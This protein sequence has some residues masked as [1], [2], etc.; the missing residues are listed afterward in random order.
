MSD[1]SPSI[2]GP[3]L[4]N[5]HPP[6]RWRLFDAHNHLHDERFGGCQE[7][8]VRSCRASGIRRMIVN[9]S[10]EADWRQVAE[11]ARRFP[12]LVQPAFGLHPWYVHERS[13]RWESTLGQLLDEHPGASLGEIGLDRWILDCPPAA[14]AAIDPALAELQAAPLSEQLEVFRR[15]LEI[16]NRHDRPASVHCLQAWGPL[17]ECLRA[18][19]RPVVGFLLHS[20]GGPAELVLP[21]AR[22][23]AY[24][25]FPGY[26]L[27]ARKARQ[28]EAFRQVPADRLLAETD[29]PDQ[30]LP[31]PGQIRGN[32]SP[33]PVPEVHQLL[34]PDGRPLNH[35]ANLVAVYHGLAALRQW[36]LA[37]LTPQLE[38]NFHSLFG[39]D[40]SAFPGPDA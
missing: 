16:A 13:P 10:S 34:S 6:P 40:P 11:L 17:H 23:G 15:Q 27:H 25:G 24:F 8:L 37:T 19:P 1:P 38:A 33:T 32:G 30:R 5:Q 2:E 29:A 31:A 26:Y 22:L 14:R 28:R 36:D 39:P 20:Y 7:D 18:G 35:P 21:L 3:L 4:R 12:D 9:G